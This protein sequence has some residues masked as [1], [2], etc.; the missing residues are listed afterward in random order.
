MGKLILLRHFKSQWNL[1]NR[2]TGWTDVPLAKE[3][4][5]KISEISAFLSS[6]KIDIV[7]TSPLVRNMASCL[8]ALEKT[9]K[10]PI[11]RHFGGKMKEWGNFEE[12]ASAYLPVFVSEALNERYYGKLQGLDKEETMNKYGAEQVRLWRR[13]YDVAPPGGES[14]KDVYKR[15]I[16]FYQK[17]T[18]NALK[19]GKNI[20]IVASH[21]SLRAIIKYIERIADNDII[22]TEVPYA[23]LLGYE[24]RDGVYKKL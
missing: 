5:G 7:Y 4:A 9:N 12:L 6:A 13:S 20:L 22:N 19:D 11:F 10:Y 2:F 1:E 8:L 23:G 15:T 17:N 21:N 24:F 3:D 16:P 18:E 14:L